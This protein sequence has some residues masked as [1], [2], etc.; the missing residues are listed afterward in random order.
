MCAKMGTLYA[1]KMQ[2]NNNT[3]KI[4]TSVTSAC[5]KNRNQVKRM[6]H[7]RTWQETRQSDLSFVIFFTATTETETTYKDEWK[8][9]TGINGLNGS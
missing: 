9:I 2:F 5:S 4:H 3:D 1:Y 7:R 6:V 8:K